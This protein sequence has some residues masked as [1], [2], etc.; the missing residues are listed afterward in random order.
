[1][2][3]DPRTVRLSTQVGNDLITA[4]CLRPWCGWQ[5][6]FTWAAARLDTIT[7]TCAQHP[8]KPAPCSNCGH[9]EDA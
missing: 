4:E 7:E 3:F 6:C 1:M 2:S 5:M 9:R 8:C